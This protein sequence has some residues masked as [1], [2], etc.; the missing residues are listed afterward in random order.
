LHANSAEAALTR[1]EQLVAEATQN[2]PRRL[3]AEAVNVII[4]M[5][6]RDGLRRVEEALRVIGVEGDQYVFAPL[7]EPKLMSKSQGESHELC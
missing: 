7:C 6:R 1:L 3:I 5:A 2:P 4:F